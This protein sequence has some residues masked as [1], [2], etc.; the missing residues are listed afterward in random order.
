MRLCRFGDNRLGLVQPV[1]EGV[2]IKDVTPA[3]EVLPSW[4]Y[5]LPNFDPLIAN[6]GLVR[7]R[8]E[9][10]AADSPEVPPDDLSTAQPRRQPRQD[11]RRSGELSKAPR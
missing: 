2:R 1:G 8:V 3:L 4:R 6:L 11:L 7:Q 5:P 9:A 10:I